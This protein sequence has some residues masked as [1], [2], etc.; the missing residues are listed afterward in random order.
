MQL[1]PREKQ[2]ALLTSQGLSNKQ[3]AQQ[4]GVT[5]G[6]IK[7]LLAKVFDKC[8]VWTRLELA[9]FVL[10]HPDTVQELS[11]PIGPE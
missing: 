2:A 9:L 6:T 7:N 1:T 8:G 4:I 10:Y 3:I 5:E 11:A